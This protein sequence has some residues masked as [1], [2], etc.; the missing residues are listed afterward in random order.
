MITPKQR[1]KLKK[2]SHSYK[3]LI[4]IGKGGLSENTFKQ[5]DDTLNK[6]EVMKIKILNNNLD[7]RDEL[8]NQILTELNCDF[9]RYMGNILTI[10]RESEDKVIDLDD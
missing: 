8:I 1:A 10:Y 2:I 3:P 4:N 7:D 6:R 9:V 5:I